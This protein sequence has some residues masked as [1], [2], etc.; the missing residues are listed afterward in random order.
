MNAFSFQ[1]H[2]VTIKSLYHFLKED[3]YELFCHTS[4]MEQQESK[5]VLN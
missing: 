4:P 2:K 5:I 3:S 1:L